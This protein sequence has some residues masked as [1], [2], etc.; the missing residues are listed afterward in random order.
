MGRLRVLSGREL[1]RILNST[2]SPRFDAES[3][4]SEGTTTVPV[5][6]HG[7]LAIGTLLSIVR[8]SRLPRVAFES[9]E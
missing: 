1:C 7:E 3:R 6:D 9:P 8:Q 2:D 5:P 4:T